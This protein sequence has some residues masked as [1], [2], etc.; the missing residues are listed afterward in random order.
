MEKF[1]E[2]K[3]RKFGHPLHFV[4]ESGT[5]LAQAD[6]KL[7]AKE[8]EV[9]AGALWRDVVVVPLQNLKGGTVLAIGLMN[10][11]EQWL[12]ADRGPR[13]WGDRRLLIPLPVDPP[14]TAPAFN[15]F[16]QAVNAKHIVGW[17]WN[18]ETP[19]TPVRVEIL[20]D[21]RPITNVIATEFRPDLLAGGIGDGKHGFRIDTPSQLRDGKAHK[22]QARIVNASS[23]LR[24]SPRI[25]ICNSNAK[26]NGQ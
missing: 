8:A 9:S 20:A 26:A 12:L 10:S 2:A 5:I 25:L 15:G 14:A 23:E 19:D 7:D 3:A 13:D 1:G 4:D 21:G 22:I 24:N 11:G 17:L 6:Y 16:L 18:K